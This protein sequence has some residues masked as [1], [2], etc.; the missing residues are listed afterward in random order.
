A[1]I[2]EIIGRMLDAD[3]FPWVA[4]KKRPTEKERHRAATIV[5]DRLCGAV[6]DPII[7]NA[8]EKRQLQVLSGYL[9]GKGYVLKPHPG[10]KPIT[11]MQPGT[12]AVRMNVT[13]GEALQ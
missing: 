2:A 7:R 6:S 5:A 12:F 9:K 1:S 13:V 4:S 10:G 11:E 8:Q 3:I